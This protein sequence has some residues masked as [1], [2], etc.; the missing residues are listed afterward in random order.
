MGLQGFERRLERMVEGTF[1]RLFRSGLR[2]VELGR[3]LVRE[4]DDGRS[5]DVR[6]RTIVPNHFTV[7]LAPDDHEQFAEVH[8]SLCRELADAARDRARDEH[9]HFVGPVHVELD[10]D[11]SLRTGSFR[12]EARL[13]EGEGGTSPGSLLLP[14]GTRVELGRDPTILGRLSACEVT[15]HDPNV[16][17]RHAEIRPSGDGFRVIDLG[18]TNG[19]RVNGIRISERDLVD[20]D[21]V[22]LGHTTVTFQES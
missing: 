8:E 7:H 19:T 13:R 17:R 12:I 22:S 4:M 11:P 6:G 15:I 18:S 3:R 20:G 21:E 14:D 1:A 10:P 2:P 9:Y 5:V 16:S